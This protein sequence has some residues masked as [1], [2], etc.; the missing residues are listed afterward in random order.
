MA[1]KTK[2]IDYNTGSGHILAMPD[3]Y[4]AIARLLPKDDELAETVE[5]RKIVKAGT[6]YPANDATAWGV[7]MHDYDVTDG[8]VNAAVIIHGFLRKDR[9][10]EPTDAAIDA[11]GRQISVLD[12]DGVVPAIVPE[13]T[14]ETDPLFTAWL[15]TDPIPDPDPDPED[16][17]GTP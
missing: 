10:N 13:V 17:E 5:G 3:H 6:M 15:D 14:T 16:P 7:I 1:M 11:I 9:L 8:D 4:V 2:Y 12:A